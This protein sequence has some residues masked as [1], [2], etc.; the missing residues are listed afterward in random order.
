MDGL[1]QYGA[2]RFGRLILATIRKSVGLLKGLISS[3]KS[4]KL[5]VFLTTCNRY[6]IGTCLSE[7]LQALQIFLSASSRYVDVHHVLCIM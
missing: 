5:V 3:R 4:N 2:E 1:D 7:Q 6:M